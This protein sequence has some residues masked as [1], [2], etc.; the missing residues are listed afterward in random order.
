LVSVS[1]IPAFLGSVGIT[2]V[3]AAVALVSILVFIHEF[4]HFIFAKL[5]GVRVL[6]FSIGF[7]R[8]MFGFKHGGTDYRVCLLPIGGFVQM[9]GADP[10]MDGGEVGAWESPGNFL[11]KPV[12]QRLI[13][14]SAGPIFN[15]ML[16]VVVFT[17]LYMGGEPQQTS[18]VGTV[19]A[20]TPGLEAGVTPGDRIV[21]VGGQPVAFWGELYDTFGSD[22]RDG[23]V[24]L[25]LERDG[26]RR[27]V[28]IPVPEGAEYTK[29][30]GLSPLELGLDFAHPDAVIGVSDPDSPA[31]V[32]GLESFDRVLSVDGAEVVNYHEILWALEAAGESAVVRYGRVVDGEPVEGE[33]TVKT[34]GS[35][36]PPRL[37][38]EDPIGNAWGV[39]P[40]YI[41]V[42]Q[43][44]ED[45][46]AQVA[47]ILRGDRIAGINGEGIIAWRE[48][49]E[50]V[51]DTWGDE[52]PDDAVPVS[53]TLVRGGRVLDVKLTPEIIRDTDVFG[54][55]RRRARI[56]IGAGGSVVGGPEEKRF[57]SFSEALPKAA[58]ETLA[59]SRFVVEQVG[60]LL[61]GEA[62]P[63]KTLGGPLQIFRDAKAAAEDGIYTW[64]RMMGI[65]SISLGIINF[66]PV[67]VL[68]GGQFLF[69]LIEGIRGRPVSLVIR[70]R[71]Q[72]IGVLF[73][74][75]LMLTVLV[76]DVNRALQ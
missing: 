72:Q 28:S 26:A 21:E 67:P 61:T 15:L 1:T 53:L 12:W 46:P 75:A 4:G 35:W 66:L 9:E 41:F 73:L 36:E 23:A 32:A 2:G 19:V 29:D 25:V 6:V 27:S 51:A 7:G 59:L 55:Y 52:T 74:V 76:F 18:A 38:F 57:Y 62:A 31:A 40:S 37:P 68:D 56:G 24:E 39:A 64:A 22:A 45:S 20:G 69:Y 60:K 17:G 65:L 14:V 48:V 44:L 58:G 33:V 50:R 43:I 42:G 5:F 10:F 54:R 47:N 34:D 8:R 3:V 13:I 63:S 16:P 70:E 49:I 71:A 11:K 30:G